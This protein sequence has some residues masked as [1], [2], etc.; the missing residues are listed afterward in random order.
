[1][2]SVGTWSSYVL[3]WL[4]IKIG[5][6]GRIGNCIFLGNMSFFMRVI[7]DR[8]GYKNYDDKFN[9]RSLHKVDSPL[10]EFP[11]NIVAQIPIKI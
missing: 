7:F 8:H 1:M 4:D 10:K 9:G 2:Y 11:T 3:Q 6:Q 5:H